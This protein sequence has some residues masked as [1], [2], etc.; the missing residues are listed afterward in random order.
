MS[1]NPSGL[2]HRIA[3]LLRRYWPILLIFV[4]ALFLRTAK[5]GELPGSFYE[6]E[7]LSGYLGRY[8]WQNGTDLYGNPW[9]LL[10]FNKF[11]DYYIILPMYLD[12]LSTYIFGVTEFATRFPT[13][14]LG[15]LSVFPI[16]GLAS[17]IFSNRKTGYLAGLF[18]AILPWHVVLSRATTESVI[19]MFFLLCG[20]WAILVAL[21]KQRWRFYILAVGL[22]GLSYLIY[23]TARV[24][25]PLIM[26]GATLIWFWQLK[27]NWWWRLSMVVT[28]TAFILLTLYIG[29]TA[30]GRG[31]FAQTSI[32]SE[33]SGVMIRIN[34]LTFN[35]GHDSAL[36]ARVFHNKLLGYGR[37]FL[38]QYG[39]YYSPQFLFF[40]GWQDTRYAVPEAGP[41]LLTM[42][43]LFLTFL[44]PT[45][46]KLSPDK[47]LL[48]FLA[49][50]WLI[51]P[52]PAATTVIESPNVRRSILISVPLV[53][54]AGW[55][56]TRILIWSR[57]RWIGL[58]V[59]LLI[60]TETCYVG[61]MYYY[62]FDLTASEYRSDA[63]T[64]VA[65]FI[66][67]EGKNYDEVVV[68]NRTT[69][70]AYYLFAK[71]DF[72]P[73]WA[74]QFQFGLMIDQIDNVTLVNDD[75]VSGDYYAHHQVKPNSLYI[76]SR[77]CV[78]DTSQL[79]EIG[80]IYGSNPKRGYRVLRPLL[81]PTPTPATLP[82]N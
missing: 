10:Y 13:A 25:V 19:E 42:G 46:R 59:G 75:C 61:F 43:L 55:A 49:L 17:M 3:N 32:L 54:T 79:A 31:R 58:L 48:L 36:V 26:I 18:L 78:T 9:P 70:P 53:I 41:V 20:I 57:G 73:N 8:L 45:N 16:F 71:K 23:H 33:Q 37:E 28:T 72:A 76:E 67:T 24:Y 21:Q 11:G 69:F 81:P 2:G 7:V 38:F 6:D 63:M 77:S 60:L 22:F 15:A 82:A 44:I 66:L 29:T 56:M 64:Q 5:L 27:K 65:D 35:L 62:H 51:A 50:L 40:T 74:Q 12:G 4:L 68:A 47:K 14:L 80:Q 52:I 1:E 39:Q 34:E 30:W